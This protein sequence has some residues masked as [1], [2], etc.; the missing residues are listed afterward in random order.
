[1]QSAP[2]RP[3]ATFYQE[4]C[5]DSNEMGW[6][7]RISDNYGRLGYRAGC[8]GKD[9][10][11]L[12]TALPLIR[13]V[14]Q[15]FTGTAL[16]S[17]RAERKFLVF[18]VEQKTGRPL[19]WKRDQTTA[20]TEKRAALYFQYHCFNLLWVSCTV[21]FLCCCFGFIFYFF[22]PVSTHSLVVISGS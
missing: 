21:S 5:K 2:E 22:I 12:L 14:F 15:D 3:G 18:S 7:P 4:C 13:H 16:F 11:L 6:E 1:M 8:N 17:L 19:V 9:V 10:P 20:L